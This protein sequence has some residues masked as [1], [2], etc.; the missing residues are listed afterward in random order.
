MVYTID[1]DFVA[2]TYLYDEICQGDVYLDNGFNLPSQTESGIFNYWIETFSS[3]QYDSISYLTLTVNPSYISDT[4]NIMI[5]E[6][7]SY[8]F[9]G[10]YLSEA[11]VYDTT[12][13]SQ[14]GCDSTVIVKLEVG[15]RYESTIIKSICDGDLYNENGFIMDYTGRDTLFFVANDGCDSLSILDLTVNEKFHTELFDSIALNENYINYGF[16]LEAHTNEGNYMYIDTLETQYGCD[17]IISLSLKIYKII[18][19]NTNYDADIMVYPNPASN[20]I[21]VCVFDFENNY[22]YGIFNTQGKLLIEGNISEKITNIDLNF[23]N[24][25]VYII[26]IYNNDSNNTKSFKFIKY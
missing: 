13:V 8:N 20:N 10:N 19:D 18:V 4:A 14:H 5:C 26:R 17:S 25:D 7:G 1:F 11:G 16:N 9:F 23:L 15:E 22:K 3:E 21:N 6:F 12:L 2:L 24:T